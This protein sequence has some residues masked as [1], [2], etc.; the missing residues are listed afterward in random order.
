VSWYKCNTCFKYRH[1]IMATEWEWWRASRLITFYAELCVTRVCCD[2]LS[3]SMLLILDE[4]SQ[5]SV[6]LCLWLC[7]ALSC[8]VIWIKLHG[9]NEEMQLLDYITFFNQNYWGIGGFFNCIFPLHHSYQMTPVVTLQCSLLC[10]PVI[11]WHLGA[12]L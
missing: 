6:V 7:L 10:I 9:F 5:A 4:T 12:A 11:I 2:I 8:W 1:K 3:M